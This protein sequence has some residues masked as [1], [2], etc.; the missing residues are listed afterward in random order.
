MV[1]LGLEGKLRYY[2]SLFVNDDS[3]IEKWPQRESQAS[4]DTNRQTSNSLVFIPISCLPNIFIINSLFKKLVIESL[5]I[6]VS[7]PLLVRLWVTFHVCS[8]LG[9]IIVLTSCIEITFVTHFLLLLLQSR[10][11]KMT[12]YIQIITSIY[13]FFNPNHLMV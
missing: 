12:S 9:N 6:Y 4:S 13:F 8:V 7:Y 1:V 3:P 10:H 11:V 2:F 5:L